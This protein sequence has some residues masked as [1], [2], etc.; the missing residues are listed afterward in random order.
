MG[1]APAFLTHA[2]DRRERFEA[3]ADLET[4][5][6]ATATAA[7]TA[8]PSIHVPVERFLRHLAERMPEQKEARAALTEVHAADLYLACAC[9][10][11]DPQAL[12]ALET[13]FLSDL[14][15]YLSRGAGAGV[16][17]EETAQTL[18]ARILLGDAQHPPRIAAYSGQ[19]PLVGWL[20]LLAA[21]AAIDSH[22][23]HKR[24]QGHER[25]FA[26]A[27]AAD[28]RAI[29]PELQFL[30]ARC[31]PDLEA[32]FE[33]TL[34]ALPARQASVLRLSFIDGLG[35]D[36]IAALYRVNVR[37]VQ[38][39]IEDARSKIL[40]GTRGRLAQRLDLDVSQVDTV[41]RL[42]QSQL[43]VD[44]RTLLDRTPR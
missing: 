10:E 7:Q 23:T 33:A 6:E 2:G 34:A 32:A 18:R 39:W 42:V 21:R 28:I 25:E 19:G 36:A 11:R 20:R 13:H 24:A 27:S 16:E 38:R 14:V 4:L 26:A 41:L 44:I 40:E 8:W 43:E 37:S 12:L 29:D 17:A 5:L 3:I 15:A 30:K 31:L 22:R 9:A 35:T 1:L